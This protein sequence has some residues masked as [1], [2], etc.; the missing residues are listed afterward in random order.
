[1]FASVLVKDA[2]NCCIADCVMGKLLTMELMIDSKVR[3]MVVARSAWRRATKGAASR[4]RNV[5]WNWIV[6]DAAKYSSLM[7]GVW[8]RSSSRRR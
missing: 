5:P 4:E 1:M 2:T 6:V 7:D 8:R 3:W